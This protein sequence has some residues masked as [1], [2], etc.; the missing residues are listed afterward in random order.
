MLPSFSSYSSPD[1]VSQFLC[2]ASRKIICKFSSYS[3]GNTMSA[4]IRMLRYSLSVLISVLSHTNF[5]NTSKQAVNNFGDMH[6]VI[7]HN[8]P[9]NWS[10]LAY[11]VE[12]NCCSAVSV[13]IYSNMFMYG[14]STPWF[15]C[16]CINVEV[17]TE[18]DVFSWSIRDMLLFYCSRPIFLQ[19]GWWCGCGQLSSI[20]CEIQLVLLAGQ[21]LSCCTYSVRDYFTEKFVGYRE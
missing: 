4:N 10:Y 16:A 2:V 18:S 19:L 13:Y 3:I 15:L 8:T 11:L 17:L 1:L 9:F 20:N 12:F 21:S 7:L 5:L 14:S 6:Y